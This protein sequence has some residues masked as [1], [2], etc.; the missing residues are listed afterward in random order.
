VSAETKALASSLIDRLRVTVLC[1]GDSEQREVDR[2]DEKMASTDFLM[3][4]FFLL[5]ESNIC[6][7][8]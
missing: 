5:G 3:V 1:N 7:V 8:W 4:C 6:F 2:V